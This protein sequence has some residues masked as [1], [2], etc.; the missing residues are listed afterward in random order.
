[1]E[2]LVY[3]TRCTPMEVI[4]LVHKNCME[5]VQVIFNET[6]AFVK[7]HQ[8][9][10]KDSWPLVH[11]DVV[12]PPQY[13]LGSKWYCKFPELQECHDPVMLPV[14]EVHIETLHMTDLGHWKSNNTKKQLNAAFQDG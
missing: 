4:P 6:E 8:L 10:N 11:C 5:E 3:F 1:M 12:V 13:K 2:V 14:D 7:P 9:C